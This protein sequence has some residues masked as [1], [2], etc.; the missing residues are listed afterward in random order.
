[1]TAVNNP[2]HSNLSCYCYTSLSSV[3]EWHIHWSFVLLV[4]AVSKGKSIRVLPH[5][6][7]IELSNLQKK[8]MFCRC[9][10]HVFPD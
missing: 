6:F 7:T 4:C 5:M 2:L 1:M 8:T 3:V 10:S 9:G